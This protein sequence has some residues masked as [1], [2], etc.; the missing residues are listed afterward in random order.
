LSPDGRRGGCG[1]GDGHHLDEFTV[2]RRV[3]V[4]AAEQKVGGGLSD[5]DERRKFIVT[6]LFGGSLCVKL[7]THVR[8]HLSNLDPI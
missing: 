7:G 4:P 2:Q 3:R 6:V 8:K 1:R 5:V